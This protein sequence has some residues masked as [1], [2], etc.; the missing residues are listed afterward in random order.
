[1][2]HP[3]LNV[4]GG[5]HPCFPFFQRVSACVKR[6][7]MYTRM[8]YDE[9]ADFWECRN[10]DKQRA[11]Q[12]KIAKELHKNKILSIPTYNEKTDSFEHSDVFNPQKYFEENESKNAA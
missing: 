6:E 1:M 9:V 11:L 5:T 4:N 12:Y 2:S 10:K 7:E 3:G 8:C